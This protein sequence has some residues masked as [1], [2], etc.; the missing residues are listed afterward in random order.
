M[1]MHSDIFNQI[2]S[3]RDRFSNSEKLIGDYI[4]GNSDAVTEM[5]VRELAASTGTSPAT[6]SRFARTLGYRSY[7]DM[8]TALALSNDRKR[9][10]DFVKGIS[11][12][13]VS[14]SVR[15]ILRCQLEELSET[16]MAMDP[17]TITAVVNQMRESRLVLIAAVGNTIPLGMNAAFKFEQAGINA[18][19]PSSTEAMT[20][21]SVNLT[22]QDLLLVLSTA[23]T[24]PRLA[25]IIDNAEDSGTPVAMVTANVG[26]KLAK[27]AEWVIQAISKEPALAH[28]VQLP[29]LRFSQN[30]INF[31]I[32]VLD[33]FVLVGQ[34]DTTE[35]TRILYKNLVQ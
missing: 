4:V 32:E 21:A 9:S 6:V 25:T 31:V 33:L 24:S 19:C 1:D 29:T 11:L 10:S 23:G 13:A 27:R 8:R 28:E 12:D 14:E 7:S 34:D 18:F 35:I 20:S 5:T 2:L 15:L 26:G 22:D 16:A 17:K 30:S 3:Y